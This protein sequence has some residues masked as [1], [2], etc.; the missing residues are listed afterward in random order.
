VIAFDTSSFVEFDQL[1][2]H[3]L[4]TDFLVFPQVVAGEVERKKTQ[5]EDFRKTSRRNLRAISRLPKD[6]WTAPF[7]D[8]GYLAPGDSKNADGKI[9]ATLVPYRKAGHKVILVS[10]DGDFVPRCKPYDIEVMRAE[11]F[12][13]CP[14]GTRERC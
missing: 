3:L 9:I 10:Q 5:S 11:I 6:R 2:D 4:P 12:M 13:G 14:K 1:A 8:F 7:H